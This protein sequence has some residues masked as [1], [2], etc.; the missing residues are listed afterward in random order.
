[1]QDRS[2]KSSESEVAS[3]SGLPPII[4]EQQPPQTPV[5]RQESTNDSEETGDEPIRHKPAIKSLKRVIIQRQ[6]KRGEKR[7]KE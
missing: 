4:K 5:D 3:E 7:A 6:Q 1:M 2:K